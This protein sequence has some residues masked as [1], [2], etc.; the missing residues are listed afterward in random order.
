MGTK[1]DQQSIQCLNIFSK[2]AGVRTQDCFMYNNA[3]IFVVKPR[4][5]SKAVGERGK[6]VRRMSN[7][8]RTRV[9]VMSGSTLGNFIKDIVQPVKFKKLVIENGQVT[10]YA[11]QQAK[12][13]L[14]GRNKVRLIELADI[15]KRYYGIKVLK[16]V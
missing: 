2:I 4:L 13:S 6:N 3:R 12:A 10:I 15:L 11:G 8:F 5:L 7:L 14:I 9:R 1:L 16:I